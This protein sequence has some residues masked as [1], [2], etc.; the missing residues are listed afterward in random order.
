MLS[1]SEAQYQDIFYYNT[2]MKTWHCMNK[3]ERYSN[4]NSLY[5]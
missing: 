3:N 4:L 1:L 5:F 2:I